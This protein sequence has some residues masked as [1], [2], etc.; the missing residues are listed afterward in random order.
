[1]ISAIL[2]AEQLQCEGTGILLW[3][4]LLALLILAFAFL[5]L[6]VSHGLLHLAFI[7]LVFVLHSIRGTEQRSN[8]IRPEDVGRRINVEGV[9]EGVSGGTKV[10]RQLV[11]RNVSAMLH[12]SPDIAEKRF[13][14]LLH[15]RVHVA[16]S[17]LQTGRWI[18][19]SG[20]VA[21]FPR[22][23]NPGEF[24]YGRYL[25]L[26]D[27]DGVLRVGK[28]DSVAVGMNG[29]SLSLGFAAVR[30]ELGKIFDRLHSPP[31]AAFLRGIVLADRSDISPEVKESFVNTGTIHVLAV[32]GLHVG[33][34]AVALLAIF[35][36]LRVPKRVLPILTVA[37]LVLYMVL[38]GAPPS[39]S[40]ATL[41]AALIL[42]GTFLQR[43]PEII[44]SLAVAAIALLAWDTNSLFDVGF[45]L[46]FAAVLSII[47]LYPE[48]ERII[49]LIPERFEEVKAIDY[50]FKLFAVS[51]AAQ[52]GTL[53][54]TVY[55]FERLSLISLIANILVV[56]AMGIAVMVAFATL[57]FS[58]WPFLAGLFAEV[59]ELLVSLILGFVDNAA[60][61][62]YAYVELS[63]TSL[64]FP[65]F[66]YLALALLFTL[67][68]SLMFKRAC[69]ATL[70]AANLYVV[71]SIA[72]QRDPAV[73]AT[74]ID[75]GQGDAVLV[76]FPNGSAMLVDVGPR[77]MQYDAGE[78]V[79]LPFLKRKGVHTLTA[80]VLSHPHGDHI[81]G[82]GAI[83]KGLQVGRL[84]DIAV[85]P[86]SRLHADVRSVLENHN[87]ILAWAYRGQ[88]IEPDSSC[89]VYVLHP[90]AGDSLSNLNNMS[91]VLKIVYG[92]T[93][94]LLVGDAEREA[95]AALIRRYGSFLKSDILKVGHHGSITSTTTEFLDTVSPMYA[96]I[97][98]GR[99]NKFKHPSPEVV[100][101]L[102]ARGIRIHRTDENGAIITR[103]TGRTIEL[104]QW[105]N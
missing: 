84:F 15:R 100:A 19:L 59:N 25:R 37:A 50:V 61:V 90:A 82:A 14:V 99:E 60:R 75:V 17:L 41:M 24:D 28:D 26:N 47:L 101:R 73:L 42:V 64:W 1:M 63:I 91:V 27:V 45:Q 83:L 76:E 98:V 11:V 23:R 88:R 97:S 57:G 93:S 77:T 35:G 52:L 94:L 43:K 86:Q 18:R 5:R 40:R 6:P 12:E 21:P 39:V 89:R 78:R 8:F 87:G 54:F 103:L 85:E 102:R 95:E 46:S 96:I 104:P 80:V 7:V 68:R 69:I 71:Q 70:L 30:T 33:I 53:P 51:L 32:S 65:L 20:S 38:I 29:W 10:P 22:P 56:P 2:L 16:D 3:A 44:N 66:F 55:Y 72:T 31:V 79:V 49:H 34:V 4:F 67:R 105:E 48:L 13:L 74:A 62:P 92:G 9:I 36:L 81:G 58:F